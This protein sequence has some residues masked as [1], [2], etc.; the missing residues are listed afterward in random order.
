MRA[1]VE[2]VKGIMTKNIET[3]IERGDNLH[4]LQKKTSDLEHGV[5]AG[6]QYGIRGWF[7]E[8]TTGSKGHNTE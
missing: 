5:R 4:N 8:R 2:E 6:V 3:I 1:D 7:L